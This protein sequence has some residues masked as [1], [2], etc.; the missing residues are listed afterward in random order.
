MNNYSDDIKDIYVDKDG[1]VDKINQI[2]NHIPESSL[3]KIEINGIE[4]YIK[5]VYHNCYNLTKTDFELLDKSNVILAETNIT[6]KHLKHFYKKTGHLSSE[7][8]VH[9]YSKYYNKKWKWIDGKYRT[10]PWEKTINDLICK[11]NK[12][13]NISDQTNNIKLKFHWIHESL[14]KT[15]TKSSNEIHKK[16]IRDG[17]RDFTYIFYYLNV[18]KR[19]EEWV[20]V[21]N[22]DLLNDKCFIICGIGHLID[23]LDKFK[24]KGYNV[25]PLKNSNS[26]YYPTHIIDN[27]NI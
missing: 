19:N 21:M 6:D 20:N 10:M 1:H 25:T 13:L 16:F 5:C 7:M 23:L 3:Y 26:I 11:S 17:H 4:S 27:F 9:E 22:N 14:I 8:F 15:Q 24:K 18:I 2:L 12:L